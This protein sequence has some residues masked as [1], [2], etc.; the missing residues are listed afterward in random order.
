MIGCCYHSVNFITF[1]LAQSDH[2][3]QLLLYF[4]TVKLQVTMIFL[5][6]CYH[7]RGNRRQDGSLT[8]A[9]DQERE[10]KT[11]EKILLSQNLKPVE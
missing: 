9:S 8:S 3:K 7:E 2:I 1:G 6:N 10:N 5:M 11:P 4:N